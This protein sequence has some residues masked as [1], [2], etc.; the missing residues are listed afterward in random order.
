MSRKEASPLQVALRYLGF[1][2]RTEW[3]LRKKLETSGFSGKDVHATL[4]TL[5]RYKYVNDEELARD[6]ALDRVVRRGA[7]PLLVEQEL[8]RRGV[9]MHVIERVL[10]EAFGPG[11]ELRRAKECIEKRFGRGGLNSVNVLKRAQSLLVRRGYH[12]PVVEEVLSPYFEE[13]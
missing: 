6:Q 5:R 13:V 10:A 11:E 12:P 9:E 2:A 4:E 8:R 3:E 7:G 1:R